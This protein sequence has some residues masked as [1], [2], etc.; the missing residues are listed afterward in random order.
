M[1]QKLKMMFS[2]APK[3]ISTPDPDKRVMYVQLAGKLHTFYQE[4]SF[5]ERLVNAAQSST[6]GGF[7]TLKS[8]S[9][10]YAIN[11]NAISYI[12]VP[13]E[14]Y[15]ITH[16]DVPGCSVYL[17]G[18]D[19]PFELGELSVNQF[20]LAIEDSSKNFICLGNCCFN[21]SEVALIVLSEPH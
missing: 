9:A 10:T 16:G 8:R 4:V 3:E 15:E 11:L 5:I 18:K 6:T 1:L 21:R 17:A 7:I 12:E 13:E 14:S 19:R 2:V 20:D